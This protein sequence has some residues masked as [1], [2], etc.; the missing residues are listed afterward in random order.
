MRAP[1]PLRADPP[2]PLRSEL[3]AALLLEPW[4]SSASLATVDCR[5]SCAIRALSSPIFD[6]RSNEPAVRCEVRCEVRR[7]EARSPAEV[8][9]KKSTKSM[10][11]P[12]RREGSGGLNASVRI[13]WLGSSSMHEMSTT[14]RKEENNEKER[15]RG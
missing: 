12:R 4:L 2:D 14:S 7:A 8:P 5:A 11:E 6:M 9:R 15:R 1:E 3:L 10:N 13:I